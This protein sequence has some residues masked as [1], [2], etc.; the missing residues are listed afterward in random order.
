MVEPRIL[1]VC[2]S[3]ISVHTLCEQCTCILCSSC[4]LNFVHQGGV[5]LVC[6][7]LVC[8]KQTDE[9]DKICMIH[10]KE[11]Q[12]SCKVLILV[13]LYSPVTGVVVF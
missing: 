2:V 12:N 13:S 1:A 10:L 9:I 6:T 11:V 5:S 7:L 8:C 4:L 3:L